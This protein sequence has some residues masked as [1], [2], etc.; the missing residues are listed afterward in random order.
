[1]RKEERGKED[2][3]KEQ[4]VER[5]RVIRKERGSNEDERET[6]CGEGWEVVL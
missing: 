4:G 5:K 1:V 2:K 6:G 3:E